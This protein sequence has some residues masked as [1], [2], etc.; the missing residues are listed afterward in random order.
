MTE[1]GEEPYRYVCRAP[2]H[3]DTYSVHIGYN[4]IPVFLRGIVELMCVW[5]VARKF[6]TFDDSGFTM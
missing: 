1:T 6:E 4:I 2:V 3:T 5:P